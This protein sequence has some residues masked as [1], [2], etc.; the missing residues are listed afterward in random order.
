[1]DAVDSFASECGAHCD[2]KQES[3]GKDKEERYFILFYNPE[4]ENQERKNKGDGEQWAAS[5]A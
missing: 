5:S 1:M 3:G 2:G 4:Y